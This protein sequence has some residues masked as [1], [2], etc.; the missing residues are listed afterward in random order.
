MSLYEKLKDRKDGFFLMAGPCVIEDER[1]PFE[2]AE[3]LVDITK[4]W[5]GVHIQSLLP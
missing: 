2:I 1:M 4:R 3:R 5:L